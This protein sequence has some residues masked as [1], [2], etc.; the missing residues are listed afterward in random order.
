MEATYNNIKQI[1]SKLITKFLT[2][3]NMNECE[4]LIKNLKTIPTLS[5]LGQ[6]GHGKST[7]INTILND[8]ILDAE[9]GKGA[10][11]QYPI[12]IKYGDVKYE[13]VYDELNSNDLQ[14]IFSNKDNEYC[15]NYNEDV[16]NEIENILI[17]VKEC[18]KELTQLNI[19]SEDDSDD[20][21]DDDLFYDCDENEGKIFYK[22]K[23][24]FNNLNGL[25]GPN[26]SYHFE[27]EISGDNYWFNIT[28][29]IKKVIIYYPHELLKKVTL[30]DLPGLYDKDIYRTQ[31]T[32]EYLEN[33]TDYI[34]IVQDNDRAKTSSFIDGCLNNHIVNIVVNKK[35][36]EIL[37]AITKID[38]TYKSMCDGISK[39]KKNKKKKKLSDDKLKLIS[40]EF[41][42]RLND[43]ETHLRNDIL[44]NETLKIYNV[45]PENIHIQFCS[46]KQNKGDREWEKTIN[47]LEVYINDICDKRMKHYEQTLKEALKRYYDDIKD[48]VT[49][50]SIHEDEMNKLKVITTNIKDEISTQLNTHLPIRG[51]IINSDDFVNILGMNNDYKT[52]LNVDT[53]GRT[54]TSVLK[55]NHHESCNNEVF[56][57]QEDLSEGYVKIWTEYCKEYRDTLN[58][59][60]VKQQTNFKSMNILHKLQDINGVKDN[61]IDRLKKSIEYLLIDGTREVFILRERKSYYDYLQIKGNE[62]I[63]DKIRENTQH[64]KYL[65]NQL[66]GPGTADICRDYVEQMLEQRRNT[67]IKNKINLGLQQLQLTLQTYK[68]ETFNKELESRMTTFCKKYNNNEIDLTEI[69]V[70]LNNINLI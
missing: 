22:W 38:V 17:K 41:K 65:S 15:S 42:E 56:N 60:Y 27:Y 4:F 47:E 57:L 37:L 43:T 49:K 3:D 2:D 6:S 5:F 7:L 69:N 29:F 44:N 1:N 53:H 51:T 39:N 67:E 58:K 62:V 20:D 26:E 21:S 55:K 40:T 8:T 54:L 61:E 45:N 23:D 19:N 30:V 68:S 10:V 25:V 48:Y 14:D 28:P 35:M 12:E 52:R 33:D 50:E 31:K 32:N 36:N 9:T 34:I 46:T 16:K 18:F 66:Y 11:T 24:F 70:L 63:Q 13:I 59:E 64:Y